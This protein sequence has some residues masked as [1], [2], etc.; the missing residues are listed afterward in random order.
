MSNKQAKPKQQ[1]EPQLKEASPQQE[2]EDV[3][4]LYQ[5]L[6]AVSRYQQTANGEPAISILVPKGKAEA[7]RSLDVEAVARRADLPIL[8]EMSLQDIARISELWQRLVTYVPIQ[9]SEELYHIVIV[10]LSMDIVSR[11]HERYTKLG[12][13]EIVAR[14]GIPFEQLRIS[15]LYSQLLIQLFVLD[16]F[17]ELVGRTPKL[18]IPT[19]G[20]SMPPGNA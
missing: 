2:Y 10:T 3:M 9:E 8:Q 18:I 15:G 4:L 14:R 16:V 7:I 12:L 6:D 19:P 1:P 20:V 13:P 5:V 11:L 17:T